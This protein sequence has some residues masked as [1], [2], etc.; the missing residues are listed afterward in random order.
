MTNP[1]DADKPTGI[2][3]GPGWSAARGGISVAECHGLMDNGVKLRARHEYADTYTTTIIVRSG[4]IVAQL[5]PV[6]GLADAQ[7]IAVTEA[8][9]MLAAEID[10]LK[11]ALAWLPND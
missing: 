2:E 4:I 5:G 10:R 3:V 6:T 8:R 9:K 7:R 11:A 1:T